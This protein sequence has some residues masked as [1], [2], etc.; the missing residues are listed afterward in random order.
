M[1]LKE[2]VFNGVTW[3]T[4]S[5]I[6]T[7]FL[8]FIQLYILVRY[9]DSSDFGNMAIGLMILSY[10][11][12]ILDVGTNAA[13]IHRD[14]ITK[15]ERSSIFWLVMANSILLFSILNICSPY[16]A[17]YFNS[18]QLVNIIYLLSFSILFDAFGNIFLVYLL[19]ELKFKKIGIANIFGSL[20]TITTSLIL[21]INGFGIYALVYAYLL[22][23]ATKNLYYY[24]NAPKSNFIGFQGNF[25]EI[26]SFIKFGMY[27]LGNKSFQNFTQ[28]LDTLFIGK[29]LGPELL[30]VYDIFKNLLMKPQ[31]LIAPIFTNISYPLISK[32]KFNTSKIRYIYLSQLEIIFFL[33]SPIFIFLILYS[34]EFINFYLGEKYVIYYNIF[35][36]LS[37]Y[38]I[39]RISG[40]PVGGLLL[41]LGKVKR[42]FWWNL[43]LSVV[44]I[45]SLY[46]FIGNSLF[47]AILTILTLQIIF[48]IPNYYVNVKDYINSTWR[49]Y[50][51]TFVI[52]ICL[53]VISFTPTLLYK[54]IISQSIYLLMISGISGS[55]IYFALHYKFRKNVIDF[56]LEYF[57][58]K[59]YMSNESN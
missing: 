43:V 42:L 33:I 13:L 45:L 25:K 38:Y 40:V 14:K 31:T 29:F 27:E 51:S 44:T 55:I 11:N 36:L 50:F 32:V 7:L 59:K 46:F 8:S 35:C 39:I 28:K 1:S 3:N 2:K 20:I 56:F 49:I 26:N 15:G 18:T 34:T 4:L 23:S 22:S 21:V 16:I 9:L 47:S 19:K 52:P 53:A 12:S 58:S 48:V 6:T 41:A 37:L 57:N 10:F 24:L 17:D 54:H 5:S 30:G